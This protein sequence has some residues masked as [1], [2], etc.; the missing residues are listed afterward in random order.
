MS[1]ADIS[2]PLYIYIKPCDLLVDQLI[3]ELRCYGPLN[4]AGRASIAIR[5]LV[6]KYLLGCNNSDYTEL[7]ESNYYLHKLENIQAQLG[8]LLLVPLVPLTANS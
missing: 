8:T 7:H 3:W 2:Q 1:A 5:A 4:N 6:Y